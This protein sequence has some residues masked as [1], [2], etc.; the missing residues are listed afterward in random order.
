MAMTTRVAHRGWARTDSQVR[1]GKLIPRC[2]RSR[3][4]PRTK[5]RPPQTPRAWS[6]PQ[7][8]RRVTTG[9]LARSCT[10]LKVVLTDTHA[11]GRR[12]ERTSAIDIRTLNGGAPGIGRRS[13]A[14]RQN[15]GVNDNVLVVRIR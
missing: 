15:R 7:V 6:Q 11:E 14:K 13:S 9:A 5:E 2:R 4:Y 10:V 12:L 3:Q 1:S 8:P